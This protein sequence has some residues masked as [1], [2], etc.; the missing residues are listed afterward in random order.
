MYRIENDNPQDLANTILKMAKK[1]SFVDGILTVTGASRIFT[2]DIEDINDI[3]SPPPEPTKRQP[4][5]STHKT[6]VKVAKAEV[7]DQPETSVSQPPQPTEEK[8]V[9]VVTI[10]GPIPEKSLGDKLVITRNPSTVQSIADI[11][12]AC[13]KDFTLQPKEVMELL[14]IKSNSD[15][16]ETPEDSYMTVAIKVAGKMGKD[17]VF[18]SSKEIDAKFYDAKRPA[19]GDK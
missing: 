10:D 9:D 3:V 6:T 1:R 8:Q 11:Y 14:R 15:I 17:L 4:K 12:E 18:A 5:G 13:F 16:I 7:V 19:E 2:Q